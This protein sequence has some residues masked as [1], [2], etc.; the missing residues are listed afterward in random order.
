[1]YLPIYVELCTPSTFLSNNIHGTRFCSLVMCEWVAQSFAY[2]SAFEKRE[3]RKKFRSL[4]IVVVVVV[5]L[6]KKE[7]QK[8]WLISRP[9]FSTILWRRDLQSHTKI[10]RRRW[11]QS[12]YIVRYYGGQPT[13][14]LYLLGE[15]SLLMSI[16]HF[17]KVMNKIIGSAAKSS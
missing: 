15:L 7:S 10:R 1:M 6:K 17:I 5:S 3:M 16:G 12:K 14:P 8:S 4:S 2:W 13:S 11:W 9:P